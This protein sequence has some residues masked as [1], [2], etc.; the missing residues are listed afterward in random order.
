M[1]ITK[2]SSGKYKATERYTDPLTDRQRTV[3]VTMDRN[4]AQSRKIASEALQ[5]RI[6]EALSDPETT[7]TLRKLSDL[8]LM[9]QKMTVKPSTISRNTYAVDGLCRILGPDTIVD[10][11]TAGYI[12]KKLLETGEAPGTLNERL[13]RLK[14][15]LRWG[16]QNDMIEHDLTGKLSVFHD[17]PH[18]DK[19]ANKFLSSQ[20]YSS[21][22][23][24]MDRK[25][26][27]LLTQFLVLSGL[28]YGEA[29]ALD[30]DDVDLKNRQIHVTKTY[31]SNNKVLTTAK[32]YSS[33]RDVYIQ[34]ELLPVCRQINNLMNERQMLHGFRS[35]AFVFDP[36]GN[37]IAYFTYAKYL[38]TVSAAEI[39]RTVT[40]HSLRHTHASLMFEK[41]VPMDV[42]S[43]RLGH[44]SSRITREIYVHVTQ[45]LREQD[46][47]LIRS[48]KL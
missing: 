20:E 9:H 43:R 48:I 29:V 13:K 30:R 1:W 36:H 42:I 25:D 22:L 24:A 34:D 35:S 4:T 18:K 26:Y 27:R 12:R 8:Y 40:P 15:L 17:T 41:C 32:T 5:E 37:R 16:Y 6:S 45:A 7:I 39:G 11:M 44:E 3:S 19:I 14:A 47:E 33:I 46:A 21:V 10:R 38:R 2:L 31:D 23:K 28:R